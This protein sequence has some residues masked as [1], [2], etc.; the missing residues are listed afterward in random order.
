MERLNDS[1]I[2]DRYLDDLE[3]QGSVK[4]T[5]ENYGSSVRVYVDWLHS[6]DLT[7]LDICDM[8]NKDIVEDFL[9]YLRK[10]RKKING[11]N[12]SFARIKVIFSALNNLYGY[13]EYNGYVKKNII[14]IVRKRYLKQYK[15]GY[16]PAVRKTIDA[17]EM[18]RYLNSIPNPRD[19]AINVLF[20][21]TGVRKENL[22]RIDC[23]DIDWDE[24]KIVIKFRVSKKRTFPYVFF[25]D[26][27]KSVMLYWKKRRE[28]I[29]QPDEKAFFV[30]EY[31]RRISKN[32]VYDA[33]VKWSTRFGLHNPKSAR[34]ED[35]FSP[36]NLRHCFTTYL[37][38]NGME[39]EYRKEL[40]GDKRAEVMD[41]YDHIEEKE[42]KREYLAAIPKFDVY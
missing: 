32:Q 9:K 31:G 11:E 30:G 1:E 16:E 26:E 28:M 22:R 8:D 42:L 2:F 23:A 10:E 6:K 24:K 34:L 39:R 35:H 21:K 18:S 27:C 37:R 20:V 13:L 12:I 7:I 4:K 29:A 19:K 17:D 33:V 38:R 14:L 15:K 40:R 5:I 3:L 36:H 41:L 25:D